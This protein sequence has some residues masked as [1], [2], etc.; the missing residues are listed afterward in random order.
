MIY[1]FLQENRGRYNVVVDGETV[2]RGAKDPEHELARKLLARGITGPVQTLDGLSGEPRMLFDI[3]TEAPVSV[4][5]GQD[6]LRRIRWKPFPKEG[7][8]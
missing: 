8:L 1:A 5:D 7:V 3:E 2:V 6:G 4:V